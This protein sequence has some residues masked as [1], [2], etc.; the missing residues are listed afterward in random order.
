MDKLELMRALNFVIDPTVNAWTTP[1]FEKSC[2][3][4]SINRETR[5]RE[6]NAT[7]FNDYSEKPYLNW[8]FTRN[9]KTNKRMII[10]IEDTTNHC[11]CGM[12]INR[13]TIWE[14]DGIRLVVGSECE[15]N[16]EGIA[17]RIKEEN[18]VFRTCERC[19]KGKNYG[20][21][22]CSK[23]NHKCI[24]CIENNKY[25][26]FDECKGCHFQMELD[27]LEQDYPDE[28]RRIIVEY[29]IEKPSIKMIDEIKYLPQNAKILKL[30]LEAER[31][32][33][34]TKKRIE[35]ERIGKTIIQNGK[36]SNFT[37]L[38]VCERDENY[39]KYLE[40]LLGN[41]RPE[42]NELCSFYKYYVTTKQLNLQ[43]QKEEPISIRD[44]F[45]VKNH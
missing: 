22:L 4:C 1:I 11:F 27:K 45:N 35:Y 39:I 30:K 5:I 42:F 16:F 32:E 29:D 21:T 41:C 20:G 14:R 19:G 34:E 28:V 40:G 12:E 7:V 36:Y 38:K 37:F 8:A 31:I 26:S 18:E 15:K 23:C 44:F 3:Q 24:K 9:N 17:D 33:T 43:K 25:I 6:I 2:K 13:L 10:T